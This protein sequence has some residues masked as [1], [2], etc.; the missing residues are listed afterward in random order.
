[1][2]RQSQSSL[3]LLL[4]VSM[5]LLISFQNCERNMS[6]SLESGTPAS[7]QTVNGNPD[8]PNDPNVPTT[9]IDD[10]KAP[11]ILTVD[12]LVKKCND[13]AL[14]NT[15]T[16][17]VVD[18][19][20]PS[21]PNVSLDTGATQYCKEPTPFVDSGETHYISYSE[22]VRNFILPDYSNICKMDFIFEPQSIN[23]DDH[24]LFSFDNRILASN[25]IGLMTYLDNQMPL[26]LPSSGINTEVENKSFNWSLLKNKEWGDNGTKPEYFYCL[27]E[28][29]PGTICEWPITETT[30]TIKMEYPQV[31]LMQIANQKKSTSHDFSFI[32]TGDNN[33][34]TDCQH[35][36]IKFKVEVSY[37]Q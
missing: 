9:P 8:D 28:N 37:V 23:Y 10:P 29:L 26:I 16:K 15:L 32:V 5:T 20:L 14:S 35:T 19:D 36:P 30:G 7:N 21:L 3:I 24:F 33:P 34:E 13:A 17:I 6:I 12:E 18:V 31:V 22:Q 25:S 27:G 11:P 2:I 1:M 4:L